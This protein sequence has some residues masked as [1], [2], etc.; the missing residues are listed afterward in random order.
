M[1]KEP[2]FAVN[3]S[4]FFAGIG[5]VYSGRVVRGCIFI[6]GQIALTCFGGGLVL[7]STGNVIIGASFLLAGVV[8]YIW[9]LFDAHKCS[10]EANTEDFG[11]SRK[12]NKDPWLAVFLS[13]I[14]PGLGHMY[15]RKWGWGVVFIVCL[16]IVSII[17][18][19]HLSFLICGA[20][21]SAFVCYHAYISSPVHREA[22]KNLI[23]I[24][25]IVI[26]AI[27]LVRGYL[28]VFVRE[29]VVQAFRIPTK[30]MEPTL[31]VGDGILVKKFAKYVP[32]RGD[33]VVFICPQDRSRVFIKRLVAIGGETVEIR[34]DGVYINGNR[35]KDSPFQNIRYV[36]MGKFGIEGKP[37]VVPNHSLFVLGDNSRS[38]WDSRFFGS[39]P[40]ADVIGKAYKIYWP[41]NRMGPIE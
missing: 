14:L 39:V 37:F 21:F 28:P 20:I 22:S 29:N 16:I 3:L 31:R 17:E 18:E 7:S 40:E 23:M 41:P 10:R 35:L 4:M 25:A 19:S 2:W 9:S 30:A 1:S 15:I 34:G 6:F 26:F 38:S 8:V 36:S 24:I 27:E 12:E 13:R 5:Q 32:K 11:S 33:L